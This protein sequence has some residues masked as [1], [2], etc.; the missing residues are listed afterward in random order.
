MALDF[1]YSQS[2]LDIAPLF[3]AYINFAG[4]VIIPEA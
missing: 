4:H 2:A 3:V 1:S